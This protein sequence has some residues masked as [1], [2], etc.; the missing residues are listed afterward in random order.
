[1]ENAERTL[2][3]VIEAKEKEN[4]DQK[5]GNKKEGNA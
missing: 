2:L 1:M 5:A 4:A 3:K